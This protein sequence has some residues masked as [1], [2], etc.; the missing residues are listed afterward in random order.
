MPLSKKHEC[1]YPSSH[2]FFYSEIRNFTVVPK[3]PFVFLLR[4]TKFYSC[5]QAAIRFF[6]AKY[7]TLQLYPNGHL[8]F[9]SEIQNFQ[10]RSETLICFLTTNYK[11]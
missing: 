3:L 8:F 11:I 2:S 4:N 9:Y 5:A 1:V 7:E 10:S 6:T